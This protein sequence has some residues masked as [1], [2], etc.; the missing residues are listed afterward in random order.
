MSELDSAAR[1]NLN[2]RDLSRYLEYK[3]ELLAQ[4]EPAESL[5]AIL[6]GFIWD[7][8]EEQV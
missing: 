7:A 6:R 5:E 1:A 8:S 2:Q 4:N 3:A